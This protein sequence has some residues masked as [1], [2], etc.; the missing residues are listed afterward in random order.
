MAIGSGGGL[1]ARLAALL[2]GEGPALVVRDGALRAARGFTAEHALER[3]ESGTRIAIGAGATIGAGTRIE[4][5]GGAVSIGAGAR[6]GEGVVMRPTGSI[7]IGAGC[8]IDDLAQLESDL[9]DAASRLS[10]GDGT[11]I[12]RGTRLWAHRAPLLIGGACD[13]G[14]SNTWIATGRGISVAERCDFTHAVTLDSAG[15]SI[16]MSTGSGVGPNSILYG[17]GGLAIGAGCAIAGLVMIVPANHRFARVDQPIRAQGSELLPI[18]IGDDVWIAGGAVVLG[19]ASIGEGAVVGA[20]AVVRG[21]VGAR[22]IVAGVPAREIGRR[23]GA[24]S[25]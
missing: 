24:E 13:I 23:D 2:S 17:H 6:I 1:G 22:A 5:L 12:G 11:R 16:A 19:G 9:A 8:T 20:G 21:A 15:G 18:S 4:L 10:I 7:S 25:G 14:A 3:T